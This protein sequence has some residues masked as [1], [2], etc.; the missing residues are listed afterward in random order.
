[1]ILPIPSFR[2]Q[3]LNLIV[4]DQNHA[5]FYSTDHHYE[6]SYPYSNQRKRLISTWYQNVNWKS[7]IFI[8][9]GTDKNCLISKNRLRL[10]KIASFIEGIRHKLIYFQLILSIEWLLKLLVE[11]ILNIP[12]FFLFRLGYRLYSKLE[13][14]EIHCLNSSGSW[15][16]SFAR[17]KNFCN[18]NIQLSYLL[19][20]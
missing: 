8:K 17:N 15:Q 4:R 7:G 13:D 9:F 11:K 16:W 2:L 3:S 20:T 19:Q 5:D 12:C 1:M 18:A 6:S 14:Y 10:S